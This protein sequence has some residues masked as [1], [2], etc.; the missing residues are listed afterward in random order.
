MPRFGQVVYLEVHAK[1][2]RKV[3]SIL[4]SVTRMVTIYL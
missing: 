3:L 1:G 4:S 2:I